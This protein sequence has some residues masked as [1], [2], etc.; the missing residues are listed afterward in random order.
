MIKLERSEYAKAIATYIAAK[1]RTASA[2]REAPHVRSLDAQVTFRHKERPRLSRGPFWAESPLRLYF[3]IQR[4]FAG[5]GTR[6]HHLLSGVS[7][8]HEAQGAT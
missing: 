2:R 5:Q 3:W 8:V 6:A 1:A 7:R 4:T